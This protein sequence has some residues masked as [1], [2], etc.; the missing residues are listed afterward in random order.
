[1][2]T[3]HSKNQSPLFP[4][5]DLTDEAPNARLNVAGISLS[6]GRLV[7]SLKGARDEA[8]KQAGSVGS[9]DKR[10][11][12]RKSGKEE[13]EREWIGWIGMASERNAL[14]LWDE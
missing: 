1:M 3:F 13:R 6:S 11:W 10:R 9:Y 12:R 2:N 4:I 14:T 7:R 8:T 5:V